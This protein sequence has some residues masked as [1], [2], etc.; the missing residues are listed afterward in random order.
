MLPDL[1]K[2]YKRVLQSLADSRHAT[3]GC[4]L[5]L[6]ALEKRLSIFQEAD[7]VARDC[8]NERLSSRELSKRNSKVIRIV[9]CVQ[10]IA[11]ERVDILET[12]EGF[13][14]L[15][16]ALGEGFGG[17]L[18]FACVEGSNTADFEACANLCSA[19]M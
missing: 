12:R 6:F 7:I 18:H 11:M 14:G 15:G 5:K 4:P 3:Q 10:Q 9:E 2:I 19:V 13:D 1:L 17:V 16:E 8:L